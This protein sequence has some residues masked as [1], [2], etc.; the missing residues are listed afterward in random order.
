MSEYFE[1]ISSKFDYI[2]AKSVIRTLLELNNVNQTQIYFK[3]NLIRNDP[4][5]NKFVDCAIASNAD[6]LVTNDKDFGVLHQ[7]PFPKVNIVNIDEF[8]KEMK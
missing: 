8:R 3:F 5:D 4:D 1:I 6:Y 2:T 7:I